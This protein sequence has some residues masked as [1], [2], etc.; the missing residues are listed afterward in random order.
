MT[1]RVLFYKEMIED[2]RRK[3]WMLALSGLASFMALPVFFLLMSREW[4]RRISNWYPEANWSVAEYKLSQLKDFFGPEMTVTCGIVLVVG[5]IIVGLFSFRHVFSKRMVDLYHSIPITRKQLFLVQ[6]LNGFFIWFVPML[7]GVLI[8]AVMALAFLGN[9]MAWIRVMGI[10]ATTIANLVLAFLI[11]YHMVMAAVM[12]SGNI[13]NTLVSGT[14]ISF[15]VLALYGMFHGFA[16]TYFATYY[17]FWEDTIQN[18]FWA[19]PP[20]GAVYQLVMYGNTFWEESAHSMQAFPLVMNILVMLV[21]FVIAFVAYLKRPSELA[22]QGIKIKPMRMIF[23]TLVTLLAGMIGWILFGYIT[24]VDSVGW[25]VFGAVLA[26]VLT[27]GVLDI[28]FFMDFKA[29]FKNKIQMAVTVAGT[30][31][32]CFFFSFDMLGYDTYLP[33]KEDIAEMGIWLNGYEV[34]GNFNIYGD[35]YTTK[36]R[37]QNMKYTDTEVIYAFLKQMSEK[38]S[39]AYFS[40]AR[41]HYVGDSSS[42]Y[43]RVKEK[44]GKTYYRRYVVSENEEALIVPILRD[45]SYVTSNMLIP[46]DAV[47]QMD[48]DANEGEINLESWKQYEILHGNENK[49]FAVKIVEAYNADLLENPDIFIYQEGELLGRCNIRQYGS[50]YINMRIGIY[51]SMEHVMAVLEEY[52]YAELFLDKHVEEIS[53]LEI[54]A[55]MYDTNNLKTFFGLE[56]ATEKTEQQTMVEQA[57]VVTDYEEKVTVSEYR[58]GVVYLYRAVIE[59]KEQIAE[60]MDIISLYGSDYDVLFGPEYV[61]DCSITIYTSEKET[62]GANIKKGV[63]PEKYLDYFVRIDE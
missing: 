23:K 24:D 52:G 25:T 15:A 10:A 6:Y 41:E 51:E 48:F 57:V 54:E 30:I 4:N 61:Y 12:I 26:G 32:V 27:Y 1:S 17:S 7:A 36:G 49:A 50:K 56:E 35:T 46:E 43:V 31:V 45:A 38:Q 37:I 42:A 18:I 58:D 2:L 60:L 20:V 3:I 9:A 44:S 40:N 53:K 22:E 63:L 19:A 55:Y 29:F 62:Y 34:R 16:S 39:D 59:D 8:C 33:D 14:I 28:I 5:A 21:L 13:L 11:I 47:E